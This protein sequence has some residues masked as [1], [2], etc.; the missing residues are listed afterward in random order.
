MD[1]QIVTAFLA[2]LGGAGT[3]QLVA[4]FLGKKWAE[5][6]IQES[7]KHEY[8]KKMEEFRA[9]LRETSDEKAADKTLFMKLLEKLPATGGGIDFIRSF[10]FE[11]GSFL[12]TRIYDLHDFDRV[13]KNPDHLFLDVEI[14][15]KRGALH[16]AVEDFLHAY[17]TYTFPLNTD[18]EWA[19]VPP[20]WADHMPQKYS[21]AVKLLNGRADAVVAAYDDLVKTARGKLKC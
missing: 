2:G 4:I 16:K 1:S 7:V 18:I 14:N 3:L 19:A 15:G 9:G 13:W 20:D 12:R 11:S 6:R 10:D 17:A 8:D 21:E 5:V